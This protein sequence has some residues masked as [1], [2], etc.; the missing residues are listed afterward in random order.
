MIHLVDKLSTGEM[1]VYIM[2]IAAYC[3]WIF[4]PLMGIKLSR[5]LGIRWNGDKLSPYLVDKQ[6]GLSTPEKSVDK[7]S[8]RLVENN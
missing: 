6:E 4:L 1:A 5:N 8:T 2:G 7:S 3:S